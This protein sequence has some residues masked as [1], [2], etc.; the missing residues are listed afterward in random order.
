MLFG[1]RLSVAAEKVVH[2]NTKDHCNFKFDF[3]AWHTGPAFV[4]GKCCVPDVD[5]LGKFPLGHASGKAQ[6]FYLDA[7]F[8]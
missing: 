2:R 7:D 5:S 1:S 4:L 6:L 3:I 8:R